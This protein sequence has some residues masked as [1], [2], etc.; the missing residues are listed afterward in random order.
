MNVSIKV[1]ANTNLKPDQRQ[2]QSHYLVFIKALGIQGF[3]NVMDILD[4]N[5]ESLEDITI[6]AEDGAQFLQSIEQ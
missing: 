3:P 2:V 6:S 4:R 5:V 1:K